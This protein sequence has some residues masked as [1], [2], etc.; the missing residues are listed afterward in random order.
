MQPGLG[1]RQGPRARSWRSGVAL[2]PLPGRGRGG[3]ALTEHLLA[4]LRV[5]LVGV[6]P[7]E[8]A[9]ARAVAHGGSGARGT[10]GLSST[11]RPACAARGK[12]WGPGAGTPEAGP[13]VRGDCQTGGG[14]TSGCE[15]SG[16]R[17]GLARASVGLRTSATSVGKWDDS[18][19][20][21]GPR[22]VQRP[23]ALTSPPAGL[24]R[25]KL[26]GVTEA[27]PRLR[28]IHIPAARASSARAVGAGE[29]RK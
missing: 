2:P 21:T 14:A 7:L 8:V 16:T 18:R 3:R 17:P 20:T 19:A 15:G 28:P 25:G 4:A 26:S 11:C 10:A 29:D 5:R 24:V 13:G 1:S 12:G 23:G 9:A 27:P 22:V 6:D